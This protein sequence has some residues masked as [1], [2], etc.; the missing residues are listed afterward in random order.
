MKKKHLVILGAGLPHSSKKNEIIDNFIKSVSSLNFIINFSKKDI[1]RVSFVSGYKY[2]EIKINSKNLKVIKNKKWRTTG[3][4]YSLSLVKLKREEDLIIIYSDILVRKNFFNEISN[5]TQELTIAHDSYYKRRYY[6]RKKSDIFKKEKIIFFSKKNYEFKKNFL[7]KTKASELLGLIKI[8]NSKIKLVQEFLNVNKNYKLKLCDLIEYLKIQKI[9]IKLIDAKADWCELNNKRDISQFILGSK[10]ET[11]KRL[12]DVLS[13]SIILDQIKFTVKDWRDDKKNIIQKITNNFK[14]KALIIRSSSINEDKFQLSNAGKYLSLLNIKGSKNIILAVNNVIRSFNNLNKKNEVFIQEYVGNSEIVGVVTTKSKETGSPWYVINY[15]KTK[16]TEIITKGDTNTS[17]TLFI[18]KDIEEKF[19]KKNKFYNLLKAVKEIENLLFDN[20]LDIEFAI[21]KKGL[22]TIFQVRPLATKTLSNKEIKE[23]F[24]SYIKSEKIYRNMNIKSKINQNLPK[25]FGV[26]PDWN[27]AEIIGFKPN[28]LSLSLYENLITNKNWAL[29][30]AEFG[31]RKIFDPK[32]LFNFSGTPY[33]S[34]NKSIESF[35]PKKIPNK[36][37]KK[38]FNIY[39]ELLIQ[40]TSKHDKLEFDIVPNCLDFDFYK[41]SKKFKA[42]NLKNTDIKKVKNA[43]FSIN[44]N[45]QRIYSKYYKLYYQKKI[46]TDDIELI[47]KKNRIN[48]ALNICQSQLT[49]I[50]AHYARCGFISV[51]VFKSALNNKLI[52]RRQYNY[53][54]N[55]I[56]TVAKN[57]QEDIK[58]YSN[59][60]ISKKDLLK[61]YGHLRPG[62]YDITS[63][64]YNK[65]FNLFFKPNKNLNFKI[66]PKNYNLVFDK[67]FMKNLRNIGFKGNQSQIAEFFYN[68]IEMREFMKFYFTKYLSLCLN[69]ISNLFRKYN[70]NNNQISMLHIND[71]LKFLDKKVSLIKLKQIISKKEKNYVVDSR[72][73]LPN[74]ILSQKDFSIYELMND[75]PN[76]VGN[77]N[78]TSNIVFLDSSKK[79]EKLKGKIAVINSADPGYDWIFNH[80]IAGLITKYGGVNSHMAI[81]CAEL[82]M[83]AAIG[84]GEKIFL[85]LKKSNRVII[86][87]NNKIIE[88]L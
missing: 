26:M 18:R 35:I 5:S 6:G 81:R 84:V 73:N 8:S 31:Y 50:F 53:F 30:R 22:I 57:F 65:N 38:L 78:C 74:L 32:L 71:I 34:V 40:N 82:N 46:L 51:I 87:P 25:I 83:T 41:W 49:K 72:C 28:P 56:K 68:S 13:K 29:Q 3:P 12:Q 54:F 76:F 79:K 55:S 75:E 61:K 14:N 24:H 47:K 77:K 16:N 17:K 66:L 42:Y 15:K 19:L 37:S 64:C 69:D 70:L 11:L 52:S 36:L 62:T 67:R 85:D 45:A 9:K 21:S 60:E 7:P 88:T 27:P 2:K 86:N 63:E 80:K 39:L 20:N 33:V 59:Y 1:S 43:L 44:L 10:S 48:T 58:S 4:I 23:V